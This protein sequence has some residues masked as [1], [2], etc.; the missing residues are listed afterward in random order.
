MGSKRLQAT[1]DMK[2]L[3]HIPR[4]TPGLQICWILGA[5]IP[6]YGGCIRA[7]KTIASAVTGSGSAQLTLRLECEE[8][9]LAVTPRGETRAPVALATP[10]GGFQ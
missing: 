5:A 2:L 10:L 4:F 9:N 1:K 3:S 7:I 6:C 8:K